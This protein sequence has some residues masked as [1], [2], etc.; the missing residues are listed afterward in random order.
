M[1][2]INK[3][4]NEDKINA[5]VIEFNREVVS[6]QVL[7]LHHDDEDGFMSAAVVDAYIDSI[8]ADDTEESVFKAVQY[9]Q[10]V[11]WEL[12]SDDTNVIIVDFSYKAEIL[13][14]INSKAKSLFVFDHHSNNSD[15]VINHPRMIFDTAS[16]CCLNIFNLLFKGQNPPDVLRAIGNRDVWDFSW[17]HTKAISS[18]FIATYD[19][20][21]INSYRRSLL[22]DEGAVTQIASVGQ[23]LVNQ[24]R[25]VSDQMAKKAIPVTISR[26]SVA[27][28]FMTINASMMHSDIGESIYTSTGKRV[29]MYFFEATG[30]LV[31]SMRSNEAVGEVG[32]IAKSMKGGGHD[33]AAGFA[34]ENQEKINLFLTQLRNGS[35]NLD[36]MID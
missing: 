7:V 30:K 17:K 22:L 21:D 4:F 31:C 13:D 9:G 10:E 25:Q 24:T 1:K 29:L 8:S 19:N 36:D 14:E 32:A 26:S 33:Y 35:I 20:K 6:G 11:P 18:G 23:I 3:M 12:I 34:I 5:L 27:F 28:E 15:E 2:V 16:G